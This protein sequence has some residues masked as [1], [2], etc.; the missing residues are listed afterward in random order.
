[1]SLI[2]T[3][4]LIGAIGYQ[5]ASAHEGHHEAIKSFRVKVTKQG[6]EPSQINVKAGT[7]VKLLVTRTTDDTCAGQIVVPKRKVTK[8]LPLGKSI[9]VDLGVL[10]KG[11]VKFG[12]AMNMM[13]SGIIRAR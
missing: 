12:C 1:M 7:H 9:E 11:E 4:G 5:S 3:A 6:F 8:E 13:K 2:S 10:K